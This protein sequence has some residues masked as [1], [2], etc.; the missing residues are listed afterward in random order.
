VGITRDNVAAGQAPV[1]SNDLT[2][3][4]NHI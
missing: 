4:G 3:L 2:D 1:I